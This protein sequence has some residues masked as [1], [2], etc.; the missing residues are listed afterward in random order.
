MEQGNRR[1]ENG[2]HSGWSAPVAGFC[3]IGSIVCVLVL[4]ACA[5]STAPAAATVFVSDETGGVVATIDPE[6]GTVLERIAV[7]KRPRGIRLT[8][9]GRHLLVALSGSP[10]AGPGTD[11]SQLPP[12]D[13]SAD[14]IGL[15]S[16]DDRKLVRILPSGQ[17]PEAFDIS[18]DGN[19]IYVSNEETAEVSVLDLKD[20]TIRARVPVGEEPEGVTVSP[21]G[22]FVYVTCEADNEVVAIDTT[23]LAVIQRM[24]TA[25]RPRSVVFTADGATAFVT[26]ENGAAVTVV[27]A[28]SHSPSATIKIPELPGAQ[29]A[30][31]PMGAVLALDGREM[32]VT[33]GRAR[34]V[35]VIDVAERRVTR[36]VPDVGT[37]PW[38][39][40][41]SADGKKVYTA[42]GPS[43]DVSVIDVA[44]G[45]VERR[46][47]TGGSPWG[48][49]SR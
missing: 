41:I 39:I 19:T 32:Y 48:V 35:A 6:M 12:A 8:R 36:T 10:I 44:S 42:N 2:E 22:R 20:G 7:G 13:R 11:E 37:R 43:G 1:K 40:A 23:S 47:N 9:D 34:S 17:D 38:G 28:R 18:P 49:V 31:R 26:A 3:C 29:I 46:I 25:P 15:I 33:L 30:P 14:G 5:R 16:L 24:R 21:D 27:E 45:R 4:V